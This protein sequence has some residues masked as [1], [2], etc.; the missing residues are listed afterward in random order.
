MI[1]RCNCEKAGCDVGRI[2]MGPGDVIPIRN[3]PLPVC[4]A[5][6]AQP[7][8]PSSNWLYYSH[9]SSPS[10]FH[11]V[12]L[13]W[14]VPGRVDRAPERWQAAGALWSNSA[15]VLGPL[16]A[17]GIVKLTCQLRTLRKKLPN[18]STEKKK[19]SGGYRAPMP[20]GQDG[21]TTDGVTQRKKG[22]SSRDVT[23]THPRSSLLFPNLLPRCSDSCSP[24]TTSC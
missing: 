8:A 7:L 23:T 16:R 9:P 22:E 12:N 24:V 15:S 11:L 4:P 5:L 1:G 10:L 19:N 17:I 14:T 20:K 18:R 13:F 6:C 21:I 3:P 2:R